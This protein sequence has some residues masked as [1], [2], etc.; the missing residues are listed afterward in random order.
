M[1]KK[2]IISVKIN[3]K[4]V[5]FENQNFNS[6]LEK[7]TIDEILAAINNFLKEYPNHTLIYLTKNFVLWIYTDKIDVYIDN[8]PMDI[9]EKI[10]LE[11]NTKISDCF[12]NEAK[13]AFDII[14]VYNQFSDE[15]KLKWQLE[16]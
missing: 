2:R 14:K 5:Y 15:I 10:L 6:L 9:V 8:I 12:L 7:Y 13:K 1:D 11:T 16:N 3:E 4:T